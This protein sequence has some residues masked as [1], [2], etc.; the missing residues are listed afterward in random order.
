M[1]GMAAGGEKLTELMI[2][3]MRLTKTSATNDFVLKCCDGK[4]T[5]LVEGLRVQQ[6][7]NTY[8]T[9]ERCD[10]CVKTDEITKIV[11]QMHNKETVLVTA[12]TWFDL[13]NGKTIET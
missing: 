1:V 5:E 11:K 10:Y 6:E 3:T 12:K 9:C 2:V 13:F 4:P 7:G 8:Y